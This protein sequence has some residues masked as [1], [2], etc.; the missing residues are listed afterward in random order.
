MQEGEII[1]FIC[2]DDGSLLA[3][4]YFPGIEKANVTCPMCHKKRPFSAYKP[5]EKKTAGPLTD[6]PN[7]NPKGKGSKHS[8]TNGPGDTEYGPQGNNQADPTTETKAEKTQIEAIGC[9]RIVDSGKVLFLKPGSNVIG[10]MAQSSKATIQIPTGEDR[11]MSREHLLIE[12]KEE[13]QLGYVHRAMLCREKCNDT[14][15]DSVKIEPGDCIVLRNG[16]LIKLPGT[17]LRFE[18]PDPENTNI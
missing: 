14:Y 17:T 8:A 4:R 18:I 12:V 3:A 13:P 2:P 16:N 10:R 9:L 1:Q 15:V 11:R 6:Y 7:D 5:V